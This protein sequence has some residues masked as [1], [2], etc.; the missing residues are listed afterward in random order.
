[1][2]GAREGESSGASDRRQWPA[3]G[4][5]PPDEIGVLLCCAR[6]RMDAASGARL[7][8]LLQAGVDWDSLVEAAFRHGLL[9]LLHLNLRACD[10]G[11]VLF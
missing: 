1:M 3:A 4:A 6:T 9:P 10:P 2:L 11:L 8:G 5:E 7:R